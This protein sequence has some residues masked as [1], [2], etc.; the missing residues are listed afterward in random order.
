[1]YRL[2]EKS[3][4]SPKNSRPPARATANEAALK[5]DEPA[6]EPVAGTA[7]TTTVHNVFGRPVTSAGQQDAAP[8]GAAFVRLA[9]YCGFT[10]ALFGNRNRRPRTP[11]PP[12]IPN[13]TCQPGYF[14]VV[15]ELPIKR[16]TRATRTRAEQARR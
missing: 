15:S 10:A 11:D 13:A 8:F 7:E 3:P 4:A 5:R 6:R 16:L 12:V 14:A 1:M 2:L 9:E